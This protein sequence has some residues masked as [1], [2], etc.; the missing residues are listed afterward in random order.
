MVFADLA[1]ALHHINQ[2]HPVAVDLSLQRVKAVQKRLF[3]APVGAVA[4]RWVTVGGTNGKGTTVAAL[5]ALALQ[6]GLSV[7]AYTSPHVFAVNERIRINGHAV[8][9]ETLRRALETVESARHDVTLTYFEYL[10]LAAAWIFLEQRLDWVIM[11]V[12]LGGRL[13]ATNIFDADISVITRIALDHC[14]ILGKTREA[15]AAE[16]AGIM[17]QHRPIIYGGED[18][19]E[20]FQDLAQV[21]GAKLVLYQQHFQATPEAIA[22]AQQTGI[23][24]ANLACAQEVARRLGSACEHNPFAYLPATIPFGRFSQLLHHGVRVYFDVAH[25][26]DAIRRLHARLSEMTMPSY[27]MVIGML[28]DKDIE[29][30]FAI[31]AQDERAYF[32]LAAPPTPRAAAVERMLAAIPAPRAQSYP[33]LEAAFA[34]ACAREQPRGGVCIVAGSFYTVEAIGRVCYTI[35]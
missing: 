13:D 14:D 5:E 3:S 16:K 8:S 25:N 23:P 11:E 18:L 29:Q 6:A 21:H 32:Y 10:T 31:L 15:I 24:V 28:A 30:C 26:P 22:A 35:P 27:S 20:T 9:D 34:A 2:A 19:V 33:D 7:G 4:T 17:R 12:G 1:Q